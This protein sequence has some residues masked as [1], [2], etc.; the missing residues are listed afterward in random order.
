MR[1]FLCLFLAMLLLIPCLSAAEEEDDSWAKQ[2]LPKER[3]PEE[4]EIVPWDEIPSPSLGQHHYLLLCIDQW[5]SKPRP[6]GIEP[7]T[8]GNGNRRDF[9]GNTDGIVILTLDSA[10]HRIMLASIVRD[11][12]ILKPNSTDTKQYYGRINYIQ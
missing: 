6:D 8:D 9:F 11:A 10:A 2:R 1:R 7:P 3:M 4:I 12:T 5:K